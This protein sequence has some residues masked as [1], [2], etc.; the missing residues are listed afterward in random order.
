MHVVYVVTRADTLA[1]AQTHVLELA[2]ELVA[3][4]HRATILCGAG[5]V[6][7]REAARRNVPCV[8]LRRLQRAVSPFAD[9]RAVVELYGE[10]S[11][12]GPDL[13]SLHSSKAGILGRL[14]CR[15]LKIPCVFT[16]HGWAFAD[17]VSPAARR[18]YS[19][20]ERMMQKWCDQII[21][22]SEADKV[23]AIERG[24]DER[25]VTVVHNGRYDVGCHAARN[26]QRNEGRPVEIVMVGR[27]DQQKDHGTLFRALSALD[28]WRLNL[29]GDGPGQTRLV[30]LAEE[31][32]ISE[33]VRFSGL[34]SDV[35]PFLEAADVFVLITNW[36][37][38]PRSTLEAMR[39]SL[40][41][42]VSDAGGSSEAVENGVS[43]FV[44]PRGDVVAV[45]NRL[46]SLLDQ[47]NLRDEMGA[48]GRQRFLDRFTL[49]RMRDATF[50]TY[51]HV[52]VERGDAEG[53]KLIA[54][55]IGAQSSSAT[56]C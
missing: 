19:V 29:V 48:A 40:P 51:V 9:S 13:V 27:L 5:E 21:C 24:F 1:G 2:S 4:G 50:R 53:G 33:R 16:A 35:T 36:E 17:G 23:L 14:A 10:L 22:V 11:R 34:V 26:S 45:R 43:G 52:L 37:G 12:I 49:D 38:F 56:T 42:I 31:L 7:S 30:R 46:A 54:G 47:E 39:Q 15:R 44:V 8:V 28:G 32:S 3:R 20:I 25:H 41:V 18:V 55:A 6:L